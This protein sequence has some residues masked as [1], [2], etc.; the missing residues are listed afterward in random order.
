M[1][2]QQQFSSN[3]T[4]FTLTL[5]HLTKLNATTRHTRFIFELF[6]FIAANHSYPSCVEAHRFFDDEYTPAVFKTIVVNN[7]GMSYCAWKPVAYVDKK[8]SLDN[9]V[10]S[11]QYYQNQHHFLKEQCENLSSVL[12]LSHGI[13]NKLDEKL[14][15]YGM[16]I[17][18]GQQKDGW[19]D[20]MEGSKY[21]SW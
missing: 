8:R 12:L 18:F 4:I 16:N 20:G 9:Q 7:T 10:P 5:D 15:S 1:L 17:S 11:Y 2:P 3:S 19:Y 21:L 6:S 13:V 14:V